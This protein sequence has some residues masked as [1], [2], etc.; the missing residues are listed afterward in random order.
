M[1]VSNG[2]ILVQQI[3]QAQIAS[4]NRIFTDQEHHLK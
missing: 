2:N 1:E 3:L 4:H